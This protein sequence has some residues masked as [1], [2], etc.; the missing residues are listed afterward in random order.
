[1]LIVVF[2]LIFVV[3]A[4]SNTLSVLSVDKHDPLKLQLLG[5]PTYTNGE[6]PV[7]VAVSSA[8][9][10][11]CV[12]NGGAIAGLSCASYNTK[13][14]LGKFDA[15]RPWNI[16]QTTPPIGPLNG[17]ADVFFNIDESEVV[18]MIKGNLTAALPGF[19]AKYAVDKS[20]GQV[21]M[22]GPEV[23]PKGSFVLFGTALIPG[24]DSVLASDAGF[25]GLILNLDALETP[26]AVTNITDNKA[27]CW[28]VTSPLTGTG[29]LNDIIVSHLVEVDLTN[30]DIVTVAPNMNDGQGM[31]DMRAVGGR[32][33]AL[34]PGNGTAYPAAVTVFDISGGRA[35]VKSIQNFVVDGA[36]ANAEGLAVM[37]Y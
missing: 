19:V 3:N 24:T 2:Q 16:G 32:I 30:G 37:T 5:E 22:T 18:A 14:G 31:A 33:Y 12:A 7:S 9:K 1:M 21:A 34:S 10:I 23:T 17:P 4:G 13:T 6:F 28:S 36:D 25:G 29:F 35:S 8:L 26:V 27:T 11:A 15:L 20:S